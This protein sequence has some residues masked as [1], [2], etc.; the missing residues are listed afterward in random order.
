MIN[1]NNTTINYSNNT[2]TIKYNI[3]NL[4]NQKEINQSYDSTL[5]KKEENGIKKEITNLNQN[6][7]RIIQI[8]ISSNSSY[9]K[10]KKQ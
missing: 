4:I 3:N 5:N 2:S 1:K 10:R 9:K 6:K 8:K 7:K